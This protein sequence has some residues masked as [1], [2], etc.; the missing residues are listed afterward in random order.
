MHWWGVG[1]R[2]RRLV[3][4]HAPSDS[5]VIVTSECPK[6]WLFS[7]VPD[8]NGNLTES[9]HCYSGDPQN[10]RQINKKRNE[11]KDVLLMAGYSLA[12]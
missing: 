4:R 10:D 8:K 2:T 7:F 12:V 6:R 5:G 11:A 1:G 9:S 3:M